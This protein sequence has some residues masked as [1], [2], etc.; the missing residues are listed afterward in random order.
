MDNNMLYNN[1]GIKIF[2]F[3][4]NPGDVRLIQE[5]CK[6]AFE[7]KAE[8][9]YSDNIEEGIKKAEN[10]MPEIILLDL[11]LAD[12]K[13]GQTFNRVNKVFSELP[14]I[15][16]SGNRDVN[17]AL[18]LVDKGAQDYVV[19][20]DIN[21]DY[22]GR[23]INYALERKENETR[24]RHI[25]S[26]LQALRDVNQLI[27][28]ESDKEVLIE[29][30]CKILISIPGY[31]FVWIVLL[32][33]NGEYIASSRAGI[34]ERFEPVEENMKKG[35]LPLCAEKALKAKE[36]IMTD[37]SNLEECKECP[38]V[39][40]KHEYGAY[41]IQ[42]NQNNRTYGII[43]VSIPKIF[44]KNYK[45]KD[46]FHE[47]TNDI[48]F[49]L[50]DINLQNKS[51]IAQKRQGLYTRI[52][53]ILNR[54]NEWRSLINDLLQE[55]KHFSD[56]EAVAIRLQKGEDYPYYV[57]NGFPEDF[58]EKENSLCSRNENGEIER[59]TRGNPYLDCMCG[60]VIR[61]RTDSSKPFF[62]KNGSFWTNSTSDLLADTT[63][64]DRQAR[65]R[66]RCNGEG[67]E[68]VA[69]IPLR[70]EDET[71]GILQLNDSR[72][73]RFDIGLIKFYES[74]GNSIGIALRR[75]RIQEELLKR[76]RLHME[77][78]KV[79]HIGHWKIDPDLTNLS[80]SKQIFRIYG[81][82]PKEGEL[83]FAEHE[84]YIHQEDWPDFKGAFLKS[85]KEGTSF[86][87][88]VR[89]VRSDKKTKWMQVIGTSNRDEEGNITK[90]FGTKQDISQLKKIEQELKKSFE[91]TIQ[92][93][94]DLLEV[95][96][97]YTKGHEIRVAQLAV[98]IGKKFKLSEE[99]LK[100][101]EVAARIHDLG[102]IIVPPEI[103][104]KPTELT[105]LEFSYIK[106]H[107]SVGYKLLKG[108]EFPWPISDMIH[109]HHERLDGS[110]Y[111]QGLKEDEIMQEAKIL[112]VA[113][114][115]EAMSSH[116]PYRKALGIKA[117][118]EE[119]IDK[120]GLLYDSEVVDACID[121]L[122]SG[123][124]FKEIKNTVLE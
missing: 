114:V 10:F 40:L 109:Q 75:K 69:L 78:Q 48:S 5:M 57:A 96:D 38:L 21:S 50:H 49:A 101:L 51:Q 26:V 108:I 9:K 100:G 29:E 110:G 16:I 111:P 97:A 47:V 120:K 46:L 90:L 106:K 6:E 80:W 33:K 23:I 39:T 86:E 59:D 72:K 2:Y 81:I 12:S 107:P 70:C 88:A 65:T 56:F 92:I 3:E 15:I 91:G 24:I 89:I 66:N 44:W 71:V 99:K 113:D 85:A 37:E 77:A 60:N 25:N 45:E 102:K 20:G 98:E 22:L 11:N 55:I 105:E 79:A 18:E 123:F 62:T 104:S 119:I 8:L 4:D 73:N 31:N 13:G 84:K 28:Q 61:G 64:E 1:K 93:I 74:I 34:E 63:E 115:L 95:K 53:V 124:E 43:T 68:S 19:K 52:M 27:T 58:V 41:T 82:D 14:I 76:E 17:T 94:S 117:A 103:L 42:L 54:S 112:A 116:R 121:I 30:I 122:D 67:Y 118:K 87:I 35:N 36:L 32:D 83:S 7:D